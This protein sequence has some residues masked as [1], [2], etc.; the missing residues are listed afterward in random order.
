M[1]TV[2]TSTPKDREPS[3]IE[4]LLPWYAAGTLGEDDAQAVQAAIAADPELARRYE[5]VRAEFAQETA[6]GE[7]LGAPSGRD[8]RR[9]FERIDALPAQRRAPGLAE[10]IAEFVASLT[11]RTLAWSAGAMAVV[12]LMQAAT[13]GGIMLRQ[14]PA[15]Y[16]TASAP[17]GVSGK[18][19]YVLIRFQPNATAAQVAQFLQSHK[20]SIVGGPTAGGI[21]RVRVA[22]APLA[23]AELM[24]IVKTLES[25]KILGFIAATD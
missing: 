14:D 1:N 22:S 7:K 25:D 2:N 18:G 15:R 3:E 17:G 9:L 13:I 12:I 23:K 8:L 11:P 10:R 19:A 6:I 21:Y 4:L 5:W 24:R 20:L 16:E